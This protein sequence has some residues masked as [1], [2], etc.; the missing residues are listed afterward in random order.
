MPLPVDTDRPVKGNPPLAAG[1][2]VAIV[3]AVVG[4]LGGFPAWAVVVIVVAALAF[5]LASQAF[6]KR[7]E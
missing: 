1:G 3:A 6:T 4:L 7:D 5:T 2:A